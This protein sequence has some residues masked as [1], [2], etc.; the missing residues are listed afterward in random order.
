[1]LSMKRRRLFETALMFAKVKRQSIQY[2]CFKYTYMRM[3]VCTY[4]KHTDVILSSI[5]YSTYNNIL[6]LLDF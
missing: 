2:P 3:C 1:M 4:E 5:T 6:L